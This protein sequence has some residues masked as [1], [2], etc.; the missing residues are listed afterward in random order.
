MRIHIL[1]RSCSICKSLKYFLCSRN[2]CFLVIAVALIHWFNPSS[3]VRWYW[4]R[5]EKRLKIFYLFFPA[6]ITWQIIWCFNKICCGTRHLSQHPFFY[7]QFIHQLSLHYNLGHICIH[8]WC[9]PQYT[10]YSNILI[11]TTFPFNAPLPLL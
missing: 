3:G 10:W 8:K 7:P 2:L 11:A 5:F 9:V 6:F 4:N 1:S